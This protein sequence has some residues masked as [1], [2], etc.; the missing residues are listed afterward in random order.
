MGGLLVGVVVEL[1]VVLDPR[2]VDPLLE[3]LYGLESCPKTRQVL[4]LG[5]VHHLDQDQDLVLVLPNGL[6][7]PGKLVLYRNKAYLK[8]S[9]LKYRKDMDL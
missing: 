5:A 3:V 4:A 9:F 6:E 2:W 8:R 1:L 7:A